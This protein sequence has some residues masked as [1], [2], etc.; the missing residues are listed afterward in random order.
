MFDWEMFLLDFIVVN[1]EIPQMKLNI[2][3]LKHFC[4]FK[5]IQA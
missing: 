5:M 2:M 3:H 1:E 4:N